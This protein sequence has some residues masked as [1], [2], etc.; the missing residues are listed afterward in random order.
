[1]AQFVAQGLELIDINQE[2]GDR[3]AEASGVLNCPFIVAAECPRVYEIPE[4]IQLRK[5]S[6]TITVASEA[7]GTPAAMNPTTPCR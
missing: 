5:S 4:G 6:I 3:F 2:E 1:M 7:I